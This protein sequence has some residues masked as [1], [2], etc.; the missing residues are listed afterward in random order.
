MNLC[1]WR[2]AVEHVWKYTIN[3]SLPDD[4]LLCFLGSHLPWCQ[5]AH[6]HTHTHTLH[7][8]VLPINP[9]MQYWHM[10][11]AYLQVHKHYLDKI[12]Y[13]VLTHSDLFT[14]S[15]SIYLMWLFYADK[16][17]ITVT[18]QSK[19]R[20]NCLFQIQPQILI[21][22]RSR[23]GLGHSMTFTLFSHSM[24]LPPPYHH[25]DLIRP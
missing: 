8:V 15:W 11:F 24:M 4:W 17:I 23:F 14:N 12:Q 16:Q 1:F 21:G 20:K 19:T 22:S 5:G 13:T 18:C 9:L 2:A 7:K 3:H 10:I 25:F 6:T